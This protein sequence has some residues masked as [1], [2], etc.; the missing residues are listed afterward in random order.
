[1]SVYA[2]DVLDLKTSVYRFRLNA[3]GNLECVAHRLRCFLVDTE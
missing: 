1:M 3:V 2:V